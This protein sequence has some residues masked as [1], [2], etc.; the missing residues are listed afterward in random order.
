MDVIGRYESGCS[1]YLIIYLTVQM[2]S[3]ATLYRCS[4]GHYCK[5]PLF[6]SQ[7]DVAPD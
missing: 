4:N 2:V 7:E 1:L 6:V 3:A 5:A